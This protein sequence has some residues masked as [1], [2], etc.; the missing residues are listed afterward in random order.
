MGVQGLFVWI[1]ILICVPSYPYL[2]TATGMKVG[3][4]YRHLVFLPFME[5]QTFVQSIL[6]AWETV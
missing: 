5:T 4:T 2:G 1:Q 6:Y 3:A